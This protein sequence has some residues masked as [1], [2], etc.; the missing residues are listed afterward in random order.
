MV[1]L[2]PT[3]NTESKIKEPE[4]KR[5][6]STTLYIKQELMGSLYTSVH[7]AF[8]SRINKQI[9]HQAYI[10]SLR[11]YADEIGDFPFKNAHNWNAY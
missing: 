1:L 6:V 7:T 3:R 8:T 2:T 11:M 9:I 5:I 10:C 4:K